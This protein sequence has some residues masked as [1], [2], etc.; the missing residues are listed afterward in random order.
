MAPFAIIAKMASRNVL[1]YRRR[2]VQTFVVV[3]VGVVAIAVADA[4][5]NGFSDTPSSPSWRARA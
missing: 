1:K 5:M 3:F 2:S 4:F